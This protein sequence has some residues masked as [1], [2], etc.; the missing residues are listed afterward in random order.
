[1]QFSEYAMYKS[2]LVY[3]FIFGGWGGG[4]VGGGGG[5]SYKCVRIIRIARR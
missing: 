3:L 1:M 4:G 5:P 2:M